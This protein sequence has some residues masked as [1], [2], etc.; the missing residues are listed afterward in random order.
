MRRLS[1]SVPVIDLGAI[2]PVCGIEAIEAGRNSGWG[3]GARDT[4]ECIEPDP[5]G[6][7]AL[8]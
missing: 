8:Q 1:A 4:C 7:G 6:S 2:L 3:R 5:Y